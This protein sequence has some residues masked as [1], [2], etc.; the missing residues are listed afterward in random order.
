MKKAKKYPLIILI[1]YLI[2]FLSLLIEVFI[3]PIEP[4][5][6]P[7]SMAFLIFLA[8]GGWI[9][10]LI[11]YFI[12]SHQDHKSLDITG[13]KSFQIKEIVKKKAFQYPFTILMILL[14]S[15]VVIIN[16]PFSASFGELLQN[17]MDTAVFN[18]WIPLL[19][20]YQ[21]GLKK[22]KNT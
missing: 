13:S 19:I 16:L 5:G 15:I 2:I 7:L 9:P 10:L 4:G 14:L 22:D 20:A 12:G 17:Y 21:I 6:I 3:V 1:V 18:G 8:L 11:S